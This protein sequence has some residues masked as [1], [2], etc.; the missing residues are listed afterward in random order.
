MII[1][2]YKIIFCP[3]S[4]C[5]SWGQRLASARRTY[6]GLCNSDWPL[7]KFLRS[8]SP[9][10]SLHARRPAFIPTSTDHST[11]VSQCSSPTWYAVELTAA[12]CCSGSSSLA[13]VLLLWRTSRSTLGSCKACL[14][15]LHNQGYSATGKCRPLVASIPFFVPTDKSC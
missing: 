1:N 4:S 5:P 10:R 6:Q 12:S 9:T 11:S 8:T 3:P 2:I 13:P 7:S 14:Q 15:D